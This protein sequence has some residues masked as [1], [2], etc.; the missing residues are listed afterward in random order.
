[1]WS[2]MSS[3]AR[4]LHI[5]C[6]IQCLPTSILWMAPHRQRHSTAS[7]NRLIGR[8][9]K[10]VGDILP[11]ATQ[12]ARKYGQYSL[13]EKCLLQRSPPQQSLVD[14]LVAKDG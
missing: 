14:L 10:K 5:L 2:W 1:M 6:S 11:H 13:T 3:P 9:R 7:W 12:N 4:N 8:G